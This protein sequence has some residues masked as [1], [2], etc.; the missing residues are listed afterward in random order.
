MIWSILLTILGWILVVIAVIVL[1]LLIL[2]FVSAIVFAVKAVVLGLH[3]ASD[4]EPRT[5]K[6]LHG[7][8]RQ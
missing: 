5:T 8:E 7:K 2:I 4:A 3:H 1:L 6:I